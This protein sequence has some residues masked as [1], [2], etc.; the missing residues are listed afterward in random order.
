MSQ[1][2]INQMGVVFTPV[3]MELSNADT[4]RS[5]IIGVAE[6]VDVDIGGIVIRIP[7]FILIAD[8][9]EQLILGSRLVTVDEN[10]LH[11]MEMKIGAQIQLNYCGIVNRSYQLC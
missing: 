7:V 10:C 4:S 1:E 5:G 8:L 3:T 6:A 11:S 2:Y 9:Q